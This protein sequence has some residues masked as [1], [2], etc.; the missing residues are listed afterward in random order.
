MMGE[1]KR[2]GKEMQTA[3]AAWRESPS[4][5][6]LRENAKQARERY[7]LAV[8][9]VFENQLRENRELRRLLTHAWAAVESAADKRLGGFSGV[10]WEVMLTEIFPAPEGPEAESALRQFAA[11]YLDGLA[12]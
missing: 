7:C 12:E 9:D 5:H 4:D 8:S 6:S 11:E 10:A 2:L 1:A 3:Y